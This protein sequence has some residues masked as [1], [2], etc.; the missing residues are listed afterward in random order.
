M[1]AS[2]YGDPE[3]RKRILDA[4]RGLLEDRGLPIT[5]AQVAEAAGVSRQAVYNHVGDRSGLM[6]ALVGYL[7]EVLGLAELAESVREAPTGREALAAMVA[8]HAT[9]HEHII[10]FTRQAEALRHSDPAVAAAWEDRMAGRREAHRGIVRRLADE[11]ELAAGWDVESAAMVL[12][13]VTLP[14]TWDEL[15]VERG[16]STGQYR[17]HMTRLLTRA[18]VAGAA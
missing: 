12:Y 5:M 1:T 18:L 17:E 8:L 10:G 15:V 6:V 13:T 11:G 3:T 2:T 7:D 4:A 9:Y 14:R 16:W